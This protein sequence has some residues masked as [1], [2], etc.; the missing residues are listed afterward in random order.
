[1]QGQVSRTIP[2]GLLAR[3]LAHTLS[4]STVTHHASPSP[5]LPLLPFLTQLSAS[6]DMD[7]TIHL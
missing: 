7:E 5:L 6:S 1:M 3:S 2:P 4:R